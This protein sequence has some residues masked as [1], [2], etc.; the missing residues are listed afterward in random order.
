[1]RLGVR[2]LAA[3]PPE[4][5]ECP[6]PIPGCQSCSTPL[7]SWI[8]GPTMQP[9]YSRHSWPAAFGP[10]ATAHWLVTIYPDAWYFEDPAYIWAVAE[11]LR[12][13]RSRLMFG[14]VPQ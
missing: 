2:D 11:R 10:D 13:V 1:M 5:S 6:I 12:T 14:R 3:L 8:D 9:D 4:P 7:P